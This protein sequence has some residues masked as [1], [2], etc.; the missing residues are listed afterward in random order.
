[1]RRLYLILVTLAAIFAAS[2]QRISEQDYANKGKA[3]TFTASIGGYTKAG[4][5]WFDEGDQIGVYAMEPISRYDIILTYKDGALEPDSPVYMEDAPNG[6]QF[7]AYYPYATGFVPT[8][9]AYFQVRADQSYYD[10]YTYSDLMAASTYADGTSDNVHFEFH[11]MLSRLVLTIDNLLDEGVSA[12]RLKEVMSTAR[13]NA[14]TDETW[15]DRTYVNDISLCPAYMNGEEVWMVI[16][17]PQYISPVIEVETQSGKVFSFEAPS[18][19]DFR[20]G[21]SIPG[22]LL[23]D[24]SSAVSTVTFSSDIQNWNW[25]D[26]V[27]FIKP[28][29]EVPEYESWVY[30]LDESQSKVEELYIQDWDSRP[31]S[32]GSYQISVYPDG[33]VTIG[34][35]TYA[36]YQTGPAVGPIA[37]FGFPV[38]MGGYSIGDE[39]NFHPGNSVFVYRSPAAWCFISD[40]ENPYEDL[41]LPAV[42]ADLGELIS[43]GIP[44][45]YQRYNLTGIVTPSETSSAIYLSDGENSIYVPSIA[46]ID[47]ISSF[48]GKRI[49]LSATYIVSEGAGP[50][51]YDAVLLNPASYE[52]HAWSVIGSIA[53]TMWDADFPMEKITVDSE[54]GYS[55]DLYV[56]F[57]KYE[58]GE[59][60]KVRADGTWD[61]NFGAQAEG[62]TFDEAVTLSLNNGFVEWPAAQNGHNIVVD[63][64]AFPDYCGSLAICFNPTENIIGAAD[65]NVFWQI[66]ENGGQEP[67]DDPSGLSVTQVLDVEDGTEVEIEETAVAAK[68]ARGFV[69]YDGTNGIL[70][71]QGS[72]PAVEVNIG[73]VVKVKGIKQTYN[74][75]AQISNN[76]LSVEVLYN[77]E[78]KEEFLQEYGSLENVLGELYDQSAEEITYCLDKWSFPA[79]KP[80]KVIGVL[81]SS[82]SITCKGQGR[83]VGIEYPLND[84]SSLLSQNINRQC[85]AKGFAVNYTAAKVTLV[86]YSIEFGDEAQEEEIIDISIA[87]FLNEPESPTQR[88]R[89]TGVVSNITS[90]QYGNFD[91]TEPTT[92][93]S[94]YVY[95]LTQEPVGYGGKNDQSFSSLGVSNGDNIT[96]VG[97]RG[98]YQNTIEVKSAYLESKN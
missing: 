7:Y 26:E 72:R 68:Y 49:E 74:N 44:N 83:S 16:I 2:C 77:V 35:Y 62:G 48:A 63:V 24:G 78:D 41:T 88:Y 95:G 45:Q 13:V 96:I 93:A 39:Y 27:T 6:V 97:Y 79:S 33:Y 15:I 61:L 55:Y 34:N 52:E 11:H 73:D 51:L 53:G 60:F 86:I 89:L 92:G 71:Y 31:F 12:V 84:M 23:L 40:P 94:V 28:G 59:E 29:E 87:D 22:R 18:P 21:Y 90:T 67:S 20:K 1:M 5:T 58:G 30:V 17:P 9:E 57:I 82:T 47:D 80:V 81:T 50:M 46:G 36:S 98:S 3:L 37:A 4:D 25:G 14:S 65:A 8:R 66:V 43:Y 42:P 64:T 54:D 32:N 75:A 56:A 10:N 19:V 38:W 91:L 76:G 70:V 85:E 69:L